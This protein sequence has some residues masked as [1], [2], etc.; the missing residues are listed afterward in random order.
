MRAPQPAKVV[1]SSPTSATRDTPTHESHGHAV[2]RGRSLAARPRNGTSGILATGSR[3]RVHEPFISP[4]EPPSRDR[5]G[6]DVKDAPRAETSDRPQPGDS[7]AHA[8]VAAGHWRLVRDPTLIVWFAGGVFAAGFALLS[9]LVNRAFRTG[10]FDLGNMVQAVW[11][12]AHGHLLEVTDVRGH[13]VSRLAAHFDPVLIALAPLWHLWP[14]A[15]MLLVVQ[16]VAVAL[17]ALPVYWL[18]RKHARSA[19]AGLAFAIAYLLYPAT[20][21]LTLNEFHPVAFACPLLLYAFWFLDE[22]RLFAFG[23]FA[24]VAITTKEEVGLTVA[25]FGL[26]YAFSR[27]HWLAGATVCA[28]GALVTAIAVYVVVPHFNTLPSSFFDRYSAIG[29]SP[30]G[31]ARTFIRHPLRLLET[32]TT[33]RHMTYVAQLVLPLGA[34]SLLSPVALAAL[35]ELMLNILSGNAFQSSVRFHYTAVEIPA[36]VVA[37]ILGGGRIVRLRPALARSLPLFLIGVSLLGSYRVGPVLFWRAVPGA[38][39][40]LDGAAT[41]SPHD[42]IAAKAL[43][44]IPP[45]VP[46]SATNSLGAHLSN[47]RQIFSFPVIRDA[48]WIAVDEKQL[49]YQDRQAPLPAAVRLVAIRNDSRWRLV[50]ES[51][52][53]VVFEL[54]H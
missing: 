1:T 49:S 5:I 38:A 4:A 2:Q 51:D 7:D 30:A 28:V 18:G 20:G 26:W 53:I 42:K 15:D 10:R 19:R 35:P 54:A 47:R 41:V 27:R 24:A 16:A 6:C 12:T 13:Q 36:L 17:G 50:F 29:S 31:I 52:G 3:Y 33:T 40:Q 9:I 8:I 48:S 23:L 39:A 32:A 14:S 44:I 25:S 11:S 45:A 21:W 43:R 37:A 46:V 22:D 34:L